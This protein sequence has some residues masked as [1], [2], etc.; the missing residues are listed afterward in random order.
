MTNEAMNV[1]SYSLWITVWIDLESQLCVI[2]NNTCVLN[3]Q[4]SRLYFRTLV[5]S[6]VFLAHFLAYFLHHFL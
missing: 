1:L 4:T 5:F 2:D 3:G 6:R